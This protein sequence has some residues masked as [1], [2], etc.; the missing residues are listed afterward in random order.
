MKL[1]LTLALFFV[2]T[3]LFCQFSEINSNFSI[4]FPGKPERIKY[5]GDADGFVLQYI[6]LNKKYTIQVTCITIPLENREDPSKLNIENIGKQFFANYLNT[7]GGGT[8]TNYELKYIQRHKAIV[9][10]FSLKSKLS[11]YRYSNML[12]S[13]TRDYMYTISFY[14]N[15]TST[16]FDKYLNSFK[17][18]K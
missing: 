8:I 5:P 12:L 6:D 10:R 11:L 14:H 9:Y 4:T 7:V 1:Y 17:I 18:F 13:Y 2:T 3:N 15:G 16:E